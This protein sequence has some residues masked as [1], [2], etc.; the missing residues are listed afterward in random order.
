[1]SSYLYISVLCI[2]GICR[3]ILRYYTLCQATPRIALRSGARYIAQTPETKKPMLRFF[4]LALI[5]ARLPAGGGTNRGTAITSGLRTSVDPPT[6]AAVEIGSQ[7]HLL[8]AGTRLGNVSMQNTAPR[9]S[10]TDIH[11]MNCRHRLLSARLD[12]KTRPVV[13]GCLNT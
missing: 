8:E 7:Y 2:S 10:R 4:L 11:S 1:M 9:L 3:Q 6:R 5:F 13:G 12:R